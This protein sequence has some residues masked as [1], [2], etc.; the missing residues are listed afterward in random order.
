LL[1]PIIC[2]DCKIE[3]LYYSQ[4]IAIKGLIGGYAWVNASRPISPIKNGVTKPYI[5]NCSGDEYVVKFL[6]NPE[7]H[8]ALINEFVCA[9]LAKLVNLP[10]AEPVLINVSDE[11]LIDHGEELNQSI[12]NQIQ[13]GIHFG[14]K[15]IKKVVPINSTSI[16]KRASNKNI[17][18]SIIL[19][20]HIICN[21]DRDSNGGNLIYDFK[22]EEIVVIDHTHAFD[23]GPIWN[24]HQLK[25]RIGETIEPFDMTGYLYNKLIPFIDGYNPFADVLYYL[26]L[27]NE[28]H[29][30]DIMYEIPNSWDISNEEKEVLTE[31]LMDRIK[32]RGEILDYLKPV[33]PNWKGGGA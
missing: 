28:D 25:I 11:F 9:K 10:L 20:D 4:I 15:K 13:P 16:V 6:E 21:K 33:L 5:I 8:K 32:R 31:Y 7:G 12:G 24:S 17:I 3:K 18:A 27:V 23:I 19:F 26:G 22:Q 30:M 29:L 2:S 14:T 1:L